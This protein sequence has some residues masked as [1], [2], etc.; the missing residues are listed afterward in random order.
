MND[1]LKWIIGG[2]LVYMLYESYVAAPPIIAGSTSTGTTPASST[3][4]TTAAAAAAAPS[5]AQQLA[6]YNLAQLTHL[7]VN[8]LN[9]IAAKA[10]GSGWN[11]QL[12]A[13]QWNYYVSQAT[14]INVPAL[15]TNGYMT[16]AQWD[17]EM[18]AGGY[19]PAVTAWAF[20]A[21]N[22]PTGL[23][24]YVPNMRQQL[25]LGPVRTF[26]MQETGW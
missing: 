15:T 18:T 5:T 20:A 25:Q 17:S 14:G 12:N 7:G 1:S 19:W 13:S 8:G 2:F 9:A 21:A 22:S 10:Q 3:T 23:A 24:A 6:Q 11:G 26:D 16:Q 4:T